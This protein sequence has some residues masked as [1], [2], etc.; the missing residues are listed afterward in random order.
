MNEFDNNA[1][2]GHQVYKTIDE[3]RLQILSQYKLLM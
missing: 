2:E 1:G 3:N